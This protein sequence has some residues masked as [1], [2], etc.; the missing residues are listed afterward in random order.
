MH[1]FDIYWVGK[2]QMCLLSQIGPG[3]V[4]TMILACRLTHFPHHLVVNLLFSNKDSTQNSSSEV[5]VESRANAFCARVCWWMT[6]RRRTGRR[7]LSV[8]ALQSVVVN[9]TG[10]TS[11]LK[12]LRYKAGQ[13]TGK[14]ALLPVWLVEARASFPV[15]ACVCVCVDLV[16]PIWVSDD[17]WRFVQVYNSF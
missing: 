6:L 2:K 1:C 9:I 7:G 16:G 8:C 15:C 12:S 11:L 5:S 14:A 17:L 4:L 3:D 13:V 10:P